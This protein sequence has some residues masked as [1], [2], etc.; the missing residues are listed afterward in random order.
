MQVWRRPRLPNR[1][2]FKTRLRAS[3][4]HRRGERLGDAVSPTCSTGGPGP[5]RPGRTQGDPARP[6]PLRVDPEDGGTRPAPPRADPGDGG[7]RPA[8]P[9]EDPGDPPRP[10]PGGPRR[11]GPRP[12]PPCPPAPLHPAPPRPTLPC[13]TPPHS[14]R[15]QGTGAPALSRPTPGGPR[16]WGT[17]PALGGP[18]GRGHPPCPTPPRGDPGDGP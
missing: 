5:P 18:R 4:L 6:A 1:D 15:T 14:G 10:A 3:F 7:T 2:P 13:P 16:G 11:R 17:C 8:P 9:R 12:A